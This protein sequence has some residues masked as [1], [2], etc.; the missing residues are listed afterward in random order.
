M[1][2]NERVL[3]YFLLVGYILLIISFLITMI[4][5]SRVVL[6]QDE[7]SLFG[8]HVKSTKE[9]L[10]NLDDLKDDNIK[11]LNK[12]SDNELYDIESLNNSFYL[13]QN[14]FFNISNVGRYNNLRLNKGILTLTF[15]GEIDNIEDKIFYLKEDNL[16]HIRKNMFVSYLEDSYGLVVDVNI[17]ENEVV[18]FSSISNQIERISSERLLGIVIYV[19]ESF[20]LYENASLEVLVE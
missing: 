19:D 6:T 3:S 18:V 7:S 4:F 17:E 13:N 11:Q 10:D 14:Q 15:E 12:T 8:E 20:N 9:L 5:I 2:K 1:R 16:S